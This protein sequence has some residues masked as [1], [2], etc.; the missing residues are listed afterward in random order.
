MYIAMLI[1][2]WG[3]I[4]DDD[5]SLGIVDSQFSVWI[6]IVSS[7]VCFALYGW[8]MLAPGV[9]MPIAHPT[10]VQ[11]CP[12]GLCVRTVACPDREFGNRSIRDPLISSLRVGV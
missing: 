7:W 5:K 9:G 12:D 3:E 11:S 1:T 2:R 4:D 6:K 10:A 8:I